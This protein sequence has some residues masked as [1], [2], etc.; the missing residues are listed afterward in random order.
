M[1]GEPIDVIRA[2]W[3]RTSGRPPEP[4][5][6]P[7]AEDV[8]WHP[9]SDEPDTRTRRGIGEVTE[10]IGQWS[11]AFDDFNAEA[12]EFIDR[13]IRVAVVMRVSG[14]LAGTDVEV[15]T[16]ET[17]VY[18]LRDG[19]VVEVREYRTRDEALAALGG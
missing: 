7:L 4:S 1:A 18:T 3:E 15:S 13:G 12:L 8:V 11:Q 2:T 6:W 10:F 5:A 14:R 16:D 19:L 17:Q 9:A